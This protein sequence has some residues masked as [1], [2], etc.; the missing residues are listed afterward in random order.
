[1]RKGPLA[2]RGSIRQRAFPPA[3]FKTGAMAVPEAMAMAL[4][5]RTM[6]PPPTMVTSS[7]RIAP[8]AREHPAWQNGASADV[9]PAVIQKPIPISREAARA[10]G[11]Q[12]RHD[13]VREIL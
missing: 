10:N 9:R 2:G 4:A 13:R 11:H 3:R 1:M 12:V 8:E 5:S 6:V 7:F